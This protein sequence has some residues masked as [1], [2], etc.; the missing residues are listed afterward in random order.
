M[1][2][3]EPRCPVCSGAALECF[4]R[5]A[6]VPVH[7]NLVMPARDA[8][9]AIRRGDLDMTV[10][11]ACGFVFNRA[12]DPD[13]LTYGA[14][15]DNTQSHSPS[16][17]AYM[18]ELVRTM[19][20]ERGVRGARIVEVGCGK[21]AFLHR[22]V[23][24]PGAGNRGVG[25]DPTYE[26][27]DVALDG[28]LR[29][30]RRFYD[31]TTA[32]GVADV[33]VCRHVI[34]HVQQPQ[35]LLQA[36]RRAVESSPGARLFFETPCVGWILDHHVIWDFFY[37]HCSLF[38]PASM[39]TA[40]QRAG[41]RVDAIHHVFGG[42]YLWLE[43]GLADTPAHDAQPGAAADAATVGT[44]ADAAAAGRT[45]AAARAF[46]AAESRLRQ[47]WEGRLRE[48][49]QRGGVALWGAGAKGVTFANLVDPDGSRIAC[50]VDL[51]PKKQGRYLPGTGHPIADYHS[52]PDYGVESAILMNPNYRAENLA[53]LRA[54]G[55]STA[56]V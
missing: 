24:W 14:E 27:P 10:C 50:V 21:G 12:F 1:P 22:L 19:V 37:E 7:Q 15:Y 40:F 48:L 20:E 35:Q 28:R 29:F 56:L 51:N 33:I 16:F 5:R 11:H 36:V 44:A 17:D 47:Q 34:E 30:V 2:G 52:L 13:L 41:F 3:P 4:L 45:V 9:L 46:A 38:S 49:R 43:A 23:A 54:A 6:R 26:G 18:D 31:E 32:D 8:A 42:Q 25:Y 53:L 39:R 55:L